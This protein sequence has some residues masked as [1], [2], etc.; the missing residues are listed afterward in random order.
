MYRAIHKAYSTKNLTKHKEYIIDYLITS[1]YQ[2]FLDNTI[3]MIDSI[4]KRHTDCINFNNIYTP[5]T[6]ITKPKEIKEIIRTY[7]L[8]GHS[9]TPPITT[10]KINKKDTTT[11]TQY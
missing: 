5:N 2:N 3:L 4:L 8:L 7:F 11:P 1:W 6:I 9:Q 10:S